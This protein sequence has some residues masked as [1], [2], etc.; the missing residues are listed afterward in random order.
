ME[1]NN[2]YCPKC[3]TE[4]T[5]GQNFCP[6][7]GVKAGSG[8][9]LKIS[10][11]AIAICASVVVVIG[12]AVTGLV[13]YLNSPNTKF[14]TAMSESNWGLAASIY[15]QNKSDTGFSEKAN[16]YIAALF[17]EIKADF[18]ESK[19]DYETALELV[20][21][22]KSITSVAYVTSFLDKVN[23]S[24]E[25]FKAAQE[26]YSSGNY[27]TALNEYGKVIAEDTANYELSQ[28]ALT[29][30]K[31]EL[32]EKITSDANSKLA[33]KDYTV[34]I[35]VLTECEESGYAD[36]S[37]T[38][39]LTQAKN[40]ESQ[41]IRD[42]A[43]ASA[44]ADAGKGDYSAA[45]ATLK[46]V[47][48]EHSND[49][50]TTLMAEMKAKAISQSN[51]EAQ[52]KYNSGDFLG[53]YQYLNSQ[54]TDLKDT[55]AHTLMGKC[56]D[57]YISFALAEAESKANSGDYTG[58]LAVLDAG[59]KV[60]SSDYEL[61]TAKNSIN[62]VKTEK[63][64]LVYVTSTR[65]ESGYIY[66]DAFAPVKN[67]SDKV[68]KE[69]S[70]VIAMF[71]KNWYPVSNRYDFDNYDGVSNFHAGRADSANIQPGGTYGTYSYWNI[72]GDAT[73]IVACVI[74]VEFYD[75]TTW[76]NP[77]YEYWKEKYADTPQVKKS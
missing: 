42:E 54:P 3:G 71:D 48:T 23:A 29:D 36:D 14:V 25:A 31:A 56:K 20:N 55:N 46:A 17:D 57:E 43:I 33:S 52:K 10:K 18:V 34:A 12:V 8:K 7:C 32:I 16:K 41:S 39:L 49:E 53:A 2:L 76:M 74:R 9:K 28:K 27:F 69:Y 68:V 59:I 50:I 21:E 45:Y 40:E 38:T 30:V 6:K 24:K 75:G 63:E 35:A 47:P 19:I 70:V 26:A 72:E 4:L 5:E 15:T 44:N 11:K 58:A 66:R 73:N 60:F 37:I 1:Q 77:Y 62:A 22:Y 51:S 65:T 67:N 13:T 64:Q 61:A